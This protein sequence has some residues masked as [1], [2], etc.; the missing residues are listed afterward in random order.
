MYHFQEKKLEIYKIGNID[1]LIK[2]E[3]ENKIISSKKKLDYLIKDILKK[4]KRI[5]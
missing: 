1:C 4:N 2:E 3:K 5:S